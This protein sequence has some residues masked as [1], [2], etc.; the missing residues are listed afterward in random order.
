MVRYAP[1]STKWCQHGAGVNWDTFVAQ[2]SFRSSTLF[3][4]IEHCR[5]F[6][7]STYWTVF[8]FDVIPDNLAFLSETE[9]QQLSCFSHMPLNG[10]LTSMMVVGTMHIIKIIKLM[11]L[12]EIRPGLLH[13]YMRPLLYNILEK[14]VIVTNG[15][16]HFRCSTIPKTKQFQTRAYGVYTGVASTYYQN[17]LILLR[18]EDELVLTYK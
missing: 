12:V 1:C 15:F 8:A 16:L 13:F 14:F 9:L 2:F 10:S 4:C 18:I 17:A 11:L 3:N 5:T 6:P 7:K